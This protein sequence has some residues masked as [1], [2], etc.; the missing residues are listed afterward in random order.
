[1][2]PEVSGEQVEALRQEAWGAA[3]HRRRASQAVS[4]AP[5][6][7]EEGRSREVWAGAPARREQKA[8]R[9]RR[10]QKE[11]LVA[12][13]GVSGAAV[14]QRRAAVPKVWEEPEA[15]LE[16]LPQREKAD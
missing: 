10:A 1:M 8:R 2:F 7:V 15:V 9:A 14:R 16:A 5:E 11:G 13:Q 6:R 4:E 3:A 12:L